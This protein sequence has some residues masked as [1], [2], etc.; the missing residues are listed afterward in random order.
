M[1][2]KMNVEKWSRWKNFPLPFS[3]SV[4]HFYLIPYNVG[5]YNHLLSAKIIVFHFITRWDKKRWCHR[6][7]LRI[8]NSRVT[9]THTRKLRMRLDISLKIMMRKRGKKWIHS[10][11]T[12]VQVF[13]HATRLWKK[14][15]CLPLPKTIKKRAMNQR[16]LLHAAKFACYYRAKNEESQF[17]R[18]QKIWRVDLELSLGKKKHL[19]P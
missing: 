12:Y 5:M 10:T 16:A 13:I 11:H 18:K 15:S 2:S 4:F 1:L 8:C 3:M 7:N 14:R 17:R 9:L 6:F 19:K